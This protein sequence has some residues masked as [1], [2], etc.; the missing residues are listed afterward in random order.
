MEENGKCI[1]ANQATCLSNFCLNKY[2]NLLTYWRGLKLA[3]P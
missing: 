1:A 2:N 3:V